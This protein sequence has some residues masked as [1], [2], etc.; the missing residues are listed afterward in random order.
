MTRSLGPR[1]SFW[2]TG[3]AGGW[4][5]L[6]AC[7]APIGLLWLLWAG[8]KAA[9]LYR[10]DVMGFGVEFILALLGQDYA[11]AWPGTPTG[12]V[13]LVWLVMFAGFGG[14]T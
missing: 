4:M 12:L 13:V 5:V 6:L 7:W 9:S 2:H 3:A 1:P 14:L 11:R 10:G 8:A